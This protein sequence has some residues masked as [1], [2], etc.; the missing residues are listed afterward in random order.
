MEQALRRSLK[1][2]HGKDWNLRE[3]R[4]RAQLVKKLED[5]SRR[6]TKLDIIWANKIARLMLEALAKLREYLDGGMDWDKAVAACAELTV[7]STGTTKT[8]K[9]VNWEAACDRFF[10]SRSNRSSSTPSDLRT[11]LRRM[12]EVWAPSPGSP[13][14]QV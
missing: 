3:S 2:E 12:K 11:R 5:C 4:G 14:G 1:T 10:E 6:S 7:Y 13:T 8:T 9:T